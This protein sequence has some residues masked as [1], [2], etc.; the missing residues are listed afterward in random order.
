VARRLARRRHWERLAGAF[1][2]VLG[3]AVL[4]VAIIALRNPKQLSAR[5]GTDTRVVT[6]TVSAP[7]KSTS[8]SNGSSKRAAIGSQPLIVLNDTGTADLARN[9]AARFEKGG[10]TVTTYDENFSND[11]SST[12]AYYDPAISG[13]KAAARAL[14]KQYPTIKRIAARFAQLPSGPVVV[15]LTAD[16]APN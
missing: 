16:Y 6:S 13:S 4:V 11:I 1:I 15:V 2:A 12:C 9:A 14:R 3:V 8:L 5:P 7:T 10:W